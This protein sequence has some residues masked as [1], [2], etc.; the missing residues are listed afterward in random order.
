MQII[1]SN[2]YGNVE[3]RLDK[4]VDEKFCSYCGVIQKYEIY[5]CIWNNDFKFAKEGKIE[6]AREL[7]MFLKLDIYSLT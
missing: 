3:E 1:S 2:F 6:F 4:K 5:N 7:H